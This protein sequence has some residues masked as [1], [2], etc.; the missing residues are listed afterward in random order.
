MPMQVFSFIKRAI[1]VLLGFVFLWLGLIAFAFI[2][3]QSPQAGFNL[4]PEKANFVLQMQ[5]KDFIKSSTYSILFESKDQ[6]LLNGL[7]SFLSKQRKGTGKNNDFGIDYTADMILF[8]EAFESGQNYVMLFNLASEKKFKKNLPNFLKRNQAFISDHKLGILVT[9]YG[10]KPVNRKK[11]QAYT[12]NLL[13][14]N[15]KGKRS[16]T[17]V[18]PESADF[19]KLNLNKFKINDEIFI[20]SGVISTQINKQK[21]NISG[22]LKT[23]DH[24]Y[25]ISEWSLLPQGLHVENSFIS[26]TMQDSIQHYLAK[27]GLCTPSVARISMNY[28][29][30]EFQDYENTMIMTPIFDLLLTFDEPFNS[31]QIFKNTTEIEK[32][33]FMREKNKIQSGKFTYFIDSLDSKTL[34]V[35]VHQQQVNRKKSTS[36]FSL[37]GDITMLTELRE[38]GFIASLVESTSMFRAPKN[39]FQNIQK[40]DIEAL[41]K[42]DKIQIEG[43]ME[44]KK[45][46]YLYNEFLK[47]YLTFKGEL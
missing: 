22:E 31:E 47:F 4:V 2:K 36:L 19:C 3:N 20:S 7:E 14:R 30:I 9:H 33:G 13:T 32:F 5:V 40:I 18:H 10:E 1:P 42:N 38:G 46:S 37:S 35:G 41:P 12:E 45:D 44:F 23:V 8:G 17:L 26:P 15:S 29:G 28:M 43:I 39:L 16:N 21:L 34:Y 11:L 25:E 27:I 24:R 6:E